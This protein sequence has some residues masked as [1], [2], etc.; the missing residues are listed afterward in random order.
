MES[1]TEG[2]A[3]ESCGIGRGRHVGLAILVPVPRPA[4]DPEA[5]DAELGEDPG[6]AV[7]HRAQVLGA[8]QHGT[9][10][11]E[12]A[13]EAPPFSSQSASPSARFRREEALEGRALAVG[14]GRPGRGVAVAPGG[15]E[16]PGLE[17]EEDPVPPGG[18]GG[19]PSRRREAR[20]P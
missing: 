8:G 11:L 1:W 3:T 9:R 17:L 14:E 7:G 10:G 12:H 18:R 4:E 19:S 20:R 15:H 5:E 13:E 16:A 2:Q 6:H